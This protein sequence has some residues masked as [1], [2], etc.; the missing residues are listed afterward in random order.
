MYKYC[1]RCMVTKNGNTLACPE[2]MR[3]CL[4]PIDRNGKDGWYILY[5]YIPIVKVLL[6]ECFIGGERIT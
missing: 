1:T 6:F 2:L 4:N 3:K 5:Y